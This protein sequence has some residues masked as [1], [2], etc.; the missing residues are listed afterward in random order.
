[1]NREIDHGRHVKTRYVSPRRLGLTLLGAIALVVTLQAT[2]PRTA[3]MPLR[4]QLDSLRPIGDSAVFKNDSILMKLVT[5]KED[6]VNELIMAIDPYYKLRAVM[7]LAIGTLAC[8]ACIA[9]AIARF[10]ESSSI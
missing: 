8:A 6:R 10:S 4:A 1:M 2:V 5:A 3:L 9:A 7:L